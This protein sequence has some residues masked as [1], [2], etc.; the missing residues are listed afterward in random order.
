[1]NISEILTTLSADKPL[2]AQNSPQSQAEARTQSGG[3]ERF[4]KIAAM[5]QKVQAHMEERLET[6]KVSLP[7]DAVYVVKVTVLPKGKPGSSEVT[8]G[9][10]RTILSPTSVNKT[11]EQCR[12]E[13]LAKFPGHTL[14]KDWGKAL[15]AWALRYAQGQVLGG[16]AL[17]SKVSVRKGTTFSSL[18]RQVKRL[19]ESGGSNAQTYTVKLTATPDALFLNEVSTKITKSKSGGHTY[20]YARVN[21]QSLLEAMEVH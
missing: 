21:V 14:S 15:P 6:L 12:S 1:M 5:Q 17:I 4:R 20:K 3:A 8:K 19:V 18:H 7:Q 9:L 16:V 10:I 13:V 11:Q 2:P